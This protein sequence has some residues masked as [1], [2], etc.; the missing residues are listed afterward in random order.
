M[1]TL[2]LTALSLKIQL[3]LQDKHF[4]FKEH[5]IPK[6][7][8]VDEIRKEPNHPVHA[9]NLYGHIAGSFMNIYVLVIIHDK[10]SGQF[11]E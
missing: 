11:Y 3:I 1:Y 9:C 4:V 6:V 10:S 5:L 8:Q 2:T 7:R